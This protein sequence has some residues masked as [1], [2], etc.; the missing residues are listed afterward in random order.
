MWNEKKNIET[1]ACYFSYSKML[2][3]IED[4]FWTT[5]AVALIASIGDYSVIAKLARAVE[6]TI[7]FSAKG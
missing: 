1:K 2:K 3:S 6:Y 5:Y 7:C 4:T